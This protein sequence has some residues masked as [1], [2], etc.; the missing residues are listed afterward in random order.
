MRVDS[1]DLLLPAVGQ[2]DRGES[3]VT[4]GRAPAARDAAWVHGNHASAVTVPRLHLRGCSMGILVGA[5]R[6]GNHRHHEKRVAEGASCLLEWYRSTMHRTFGAAMSFLLLLGVSCGGPLPGR[7]APF[8]AS[9]TASNEPTVEPP[10]PSPSASTARPTVPEG[11]EIVV[12]L[13]DIAGEGK[14]ERDVFA[15]APALRLRKKL[16]SYLLPGMCVQAPEQPTRAHRTNPTPAANPPTASFKLSCGLLVD[17]PFE[18]SVSADGLRVNAE[19]P[20]AL[21]EHARVGLPTEAPPQSGIAP[22]QGNETAAP[23]TLD[24][25]PGK[26]QRTSSDEP[27]D[28]VLFVRAAGLRSEMFTWFPQWSCSGRV[29]QGPYRLEETCRYGLSTN[30]L[31][32]EEHDGRLELSLTTTGE[33]GAQL[34][35]GAIRLPCGSKARFVPL[36][37]ARQ[38]RPR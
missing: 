9:G 36:H 15:I 22:C 1:A 4:A 18:L 23:T 19:A 14:N 12:T 25:A 24:L 34:S 8:A 11:P 6:R 37:R 20:V 16:G 28:D 27:P 35:K 17:R 13:E 32:V 26:S 38:D 29:T 3:H 31:N 5:A 10:S 21:P 33:Y 2:H 7:P 30:T